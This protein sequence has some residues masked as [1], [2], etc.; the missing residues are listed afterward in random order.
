MYL[1]VTNLDEEARKC[2]GRNGMNIRP[3]YNDLY[4]CIL[5]NRSLL[6]DSVSIYKFVIG[7][8]RMHRWDLS[9]LDHVCCGD[10]FPYAK[11]VQSSWTSHLFRQ[12]AVSDVDHPIER[13]FERAMPHV[14][15]VTIF[16][17][18]TSYIFMKNIIKLEYTSKKIL[19]LLF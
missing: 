17:R 2:F 9:N 15:K 13:C 3:L 1:K 11:R 6:S 10:S 5:R 18:R 12:S 8:E 7:I 16:G 14:R 4:H 19:S